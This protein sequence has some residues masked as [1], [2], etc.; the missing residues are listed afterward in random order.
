MKRYRLTLVAM[1]LCLCFS[2]NAQVNGYFGKRLGIKGYVGTGFSFQSYGG[3]ARKLN[4]DFLNYGPNPVAG[5]GAGF[6]MNRSTMLSLEYSTMS[7][8]V[9]R[10]E[11]LLPTPFSNP[12][13]AATFH[14]AEYLF[15]LN[16]NTLRLDI[17]QKVFGS[18]QPSPEGWFIS[19]FVQRSWFRASAIDSI[20]REPA[21]GRP[22][23]GDMPASRIDPSLGPQ[24]FYGMSF[25]YTAAVTRFLLFEFS[26]EGVM[27]VNYQAVTPESPIFDPFD[28]PTTNTSRY[29][30]VAIPK[31]LLMGAVAFRVGLWF[32][33]A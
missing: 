11:I 10:N 26:Y 25:G 19:G 5:L 32:F 22:P 29:R 20:I 18:S 16:A 13:N 21:N 14:S 4:E 33:F 8:S 3:T 2:G 12:Y 31:G 7:S 1:A 23:L 28:I 15:R 6:V 30:S 9:S 24:D 27:P 17:R